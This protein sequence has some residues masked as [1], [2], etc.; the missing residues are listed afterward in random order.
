MIFLICI[1]YLWH[2]YVVKRPDDGNRYIRTRVTGCHMGDSAHCGSSTTT[3]SSFIHWAIC[4]SSLWSSLVLES[5]L[6][7]YFC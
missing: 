3:V 2:M 5:D 7:T 4:L 6:Q 1:L